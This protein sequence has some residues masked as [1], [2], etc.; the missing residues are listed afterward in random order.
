MK[1]NKNDIFFY[2]SEYK[3]MKSKFLGLLFEINSVDLFEKT[4]EKIISENKKA[5]H[6][7]YGYKIVENNTLKIKGSDAGEPKGS[8]SI[9]ILN[10][11]ESSEFQNIA[12]VVVRYFGGT[13]IGLGKLYR[14][15]MITS[16]EVMRIYK[17]ELIE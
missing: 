13:K 8:A 2:K 6:F 1:E 5:K 7:C 17:E 15:Y 10:V 4:L 14:A 9:P 3:I 12:I 11:I 16:K